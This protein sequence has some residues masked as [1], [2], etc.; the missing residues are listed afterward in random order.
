MDGNA[1]NAAIET[2]LT[3][4]RDCETIDERIDLINYVRGRIHEVSPLRHHP[5]DYVI[6]EKSGNVTFNDY[7]PNHVDTK[8]MRDLYLS[9]KE[10]GYTMP[11]VTAEVLVDESKPDGDSQIVIVDG[12]HRTKTFFRN[13]DIQQS[14][15]G[16]IPRSQVR[17][18]KKDR[19]SRMASTVRHNRA[20]GVHGVEP[21]MEMVVELIQL[22][23]SDS[24]IAHELGMSADEVLRLKQTSGIAEIFKNLEFT[25]SWEFKEI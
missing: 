14:T 22:G 23:W 7:N 6:W 19:K 1:I 11:V 12:A 8:K 24:Q 4:V 13:K 20:R 18:E 3:A 10:D 9:V 21:M 17:Q 15:L 25:P 5:V 16:R 2:I